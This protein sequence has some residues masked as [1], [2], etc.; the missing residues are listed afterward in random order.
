[1]T[2]GS[3][4]QYPVDKICDMRKLLS[5]NLIMITS[6]VQMWQIF[7]LVISG[8]IDELKTQLGDVADLVLETIDRH[9]KNF[10]VQSLQLD[11]LT[12]RL[13]CQ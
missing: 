7:R 11:E 13:E 4:L 12:L 1:M 3:T 10:F 8:A 9:V 2:Q 6:A 5:A